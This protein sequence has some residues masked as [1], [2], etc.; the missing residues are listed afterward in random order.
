[1]S[2]SLSGHISTHRSSWTGSLHTLRSNSA[3]L[4]PG[5][6]CLA[7]SRP[8]FFRMVMRHR[9]YTFWGRMTSSLWRSVHEYLSMFPLEKGWRSTKEA[10][11]CHPGPAGGVFLKHTCSIRQGM[12]LALAHPQCRSPGQVQSRHFQA[13][14]LGESRHLALVQEVALCLSVT[15][16]I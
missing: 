6:K 15:I 8:L 3:L 16:W 1:M 11:S 9:R 10:T 7:L 13:E 4:C 5:S 14:V 12:F 2:R